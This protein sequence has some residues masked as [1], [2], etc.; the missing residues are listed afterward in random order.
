MEE[1]ENEMSIFDSDQSFELDYD[2][3]ETTEEVE[4]TE[5]INDD[6]TE[7]EDED[8]D[9]VG[10]EDQEDEDN[11]E[12]NE[13]EDNNDADDSSPNLYSSLVNILHEQGVI[14]S[15]DSSEKIETAEDLI[16]IVKREINIQADT[17]LDDYLN[18]LDLSKIAEVKKDSMSLESINEDSLKEDVELAKQIILKDYMNQGLSEDKA[19]RYLKRTIDSGEEFLLEE[20]NESLESLKQFEKKQIEVSK[21]NAKKQLQEQVK[22]QERLD[23]ELKNKIFNSE[24]IIKGVKS[25]KALKDRVYKSMTEIVS[26]NPETGILE[27]KLMQDRAKN[28]L[29]FDI[30]MYSIYELTNGFTDFDKILKTTKSKATLDLEKAIRNNKIKEDS[31][32]TWAQDDQSY[33]GFGSELVY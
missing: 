2:E 29:E 8:P 5:D 17:K 25:N 27:N 15:L 33:D 18:N 12:E 26:K 19:K 7:D 22:E 13:T 23:L 20:A 6:Q 24:E 11:S 32:P 31:T 9:R 28:P 4:N 3:I 21:E 14:P 10:E 1:N 16:N 30:K